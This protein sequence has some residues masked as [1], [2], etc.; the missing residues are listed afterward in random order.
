MIE[1]RIV[2]QLS[3]AK[4]QHAT[5]AARD[6]SVADPASSGAD[7]QTEYCNAAFLAR[8][9]P[10]AGTR[11]IRLAMSDHYIEAHTDTGMHLLYLR[12][13]DA[14]DELKSADGAQVHRSHWVCFSEIS[15][16]TKDGAKIA[17][18]MSDGATVPISR[19]RKKDL[20]N[21]GVI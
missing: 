14:I 20:Q 11:L 12:F 18:V 15:S 6:Q 5:P 4:K 8:L 3:I 13:A 7:L 9:G 1:T 21:R 17:L 16:V 10:N 2:K 19:S